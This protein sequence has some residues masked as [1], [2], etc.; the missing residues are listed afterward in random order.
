MATYV[1]YVSL[2]W[3]KYEPHSVKLYQMLE[4]NPN[5]RT[6]CIDNVKIK[7]RIAKSANVK[8]TYVPTML[9]VYNNGSVDKY[10]KISALYEMANLLV[11]KAQAMKGPPRPSGGPPPPSYPQGPQMDQ[12]HPQSPFPEDERAYYPSILKQ[13]QQRGPPPR[14]RRPPPRG[15][16]QGRRP[17]PRGP[18]QYSP[19]PP[20]EEESDGEDVQQGGNDFS[21][22][23]AGNRSD[24]H[25]V[26]N[27]DMP[28]PLKKPAKKQTSMPVRA[29]VNISEIMA[30]ANRDLKKRSPKKKGYVHPSAPPPQDDEEEEDE[31]EEAAE[32]EPS[33]EPGEDDD[34]VMSH[35]D[36]LPPKQKAE[37]MRKLSSKDSGYTGD[38]IQAVP[39]GPPKGAPVIKP[40]LKGKLRS[41]N[42]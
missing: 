5:I 28:I 24:D 36:S 14:G 33:E 13:P 6:L 38:D 37:M 25:I 19:N 20:E 31:E 11:R 4:G 12:P 42:K 34:N 17:P 16:P 2:I 9:A 3:S 7:E 1:L 40:N 23:H 39:K 8:V 15:P 10:E 29:K 18:P 30:A 26:P 21:M 32:E 41:G 35:F 27:P 22:Y